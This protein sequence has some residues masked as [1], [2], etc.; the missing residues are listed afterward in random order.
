MLVSGFVPD[1]FL[2]SIEAIA[3]VPQ[4]EWPP[5]PTARPM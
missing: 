1:D 4:E 2:I 3:V 5:P